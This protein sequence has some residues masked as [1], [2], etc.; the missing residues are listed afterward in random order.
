MVYVHLAEGFEEIEALTVVDVLRRADIQVK[1]VSVTG[2]KM[3]K[4][5][6]DVI[7]ES[8]LLFED[9]DYENCVMIVLPGGLPGTTNLAKHEG[10]VR[11]IQA[12]A[13]KE[14]WLAAICAAPGV[15]GKL[16][17]LEGKNA[18]IYPGLEEQMIGAKHSEDRVVQ[19]GKFI[20][21][22]GPGTATDF[23]LK[24]V[25]VLKS[26][27]ASDEVRAAMLVC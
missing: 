17:L 3:V 4:G 11:N 14:K 13:A 26:R 9:A 20:T 25:E 24:L 19:D 6:H 22:R 16:S 12:F 15:L 1:M 23:A 5:A 27:H 8:D 2:N 18:T 7:V 21:S 10:L